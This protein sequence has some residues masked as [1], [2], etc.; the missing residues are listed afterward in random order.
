[1]KGISVTPAGLARQ[2]FRRI[3]GFADRIAK[4]GDIGAA[5]YMHGLSRE[6]HRDFC[7]RVDRLRS[8]GDRLYA[9]IAAHVVDLECMHE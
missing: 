5:V 1:M 6:V 8:L 2:L 4:A 7:L 9:M 3:A